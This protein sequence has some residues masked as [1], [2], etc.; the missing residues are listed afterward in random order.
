MYMITDTRQRI[1]NYIKRHGRVRPVDLVRNFGFTQA[2]IHRQLNKLL[3]KKFIERVGKPPK[4]YYQSTGGVELEIKNALA[5]NPKV[6]SAYILGSYLTGQTNSESDFDLAVVVNQN[7]S[8]SQVY[9]LVRKIKFPKDL[10]L[11]VVNKKSSPLFLYQII[12]TGKRIYKKSRAEVLA[13]EDFSLHNYYDTA[14]LR[15]LNYL[16][17]KEKFFYADQQRSGR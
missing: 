15:R 1:F 3:A 12:S 4:V 14:Y 17:L 6:I 2:A 7:I 8:E 10:D 5:K 9:N 16:A 11:S 13:F